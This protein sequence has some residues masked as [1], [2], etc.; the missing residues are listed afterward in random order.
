M[1]ASIIIN[2]NYSIEINCG[3]IIIVYTVPTLSLKVSCKFLVVL[4]IPVL[5]K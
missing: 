5:K 3:I 1:A 4:G 2:N